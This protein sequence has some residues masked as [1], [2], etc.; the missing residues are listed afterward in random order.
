MSHANRLSER[1]RSERPYA[2]AGIH[3]S[4]VRNFIY[5]LLSEPSQPVCD[6]SQGLRH[7]I[8]ELY[9]AEWLLK[10]TTFNGNYGTN[11]TL[12]ARSPSRPRHTHRSASRAE[13]ACQRS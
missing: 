5:V 10:R 3:G 13:P 11:L 7:A 6:T 12:T 9:R 1:P 4:P 2:G 8:E